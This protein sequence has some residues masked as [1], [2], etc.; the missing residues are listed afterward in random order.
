MLMDDKVTWYC[1]MLIHNTDSHLFPSSNNKKLQKE[2]KRCYCAFRAD[3]RTSVRSQES[4]KTSSASEQAKSLESYKMTVLSCIANLF[5]EN[6]LQTCLLTVQTSTKTHCAA[7][8][9]HST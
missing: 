2:A 7:W 4:C 1:S 8:C 5:K 3:F 6:K 9:T